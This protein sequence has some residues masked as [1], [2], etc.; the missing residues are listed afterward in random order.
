LPPES[1]QT[2]HDK[3]YLKPM[4]QAWTKSMGSLGIW[5]DG[6][7]VDLAAAPEVMTGP[8]FT[9]TRLKFI[10]EEVNATAIS[11]LSGAVTHQQVP[12][13]FLYMKAL[14]MWTIALDARQALELAVQTSSLLGQSAETT[15]GLEALLLLAQNVASEM[16]RGTSQASVIQAID[17][18]RP[19]MMHR[20][21]TLDTA[22]LQYA[23]TGSHENLRALLHLASA[24]I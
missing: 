12:T 13:M 14:F 3:P 16:I 8:E 23:I 20:G 2:L 7:P 18:Q 9:T 5:P 24:P 15:E 4:M 11:V 19:T 1:I 6:S 22:I 21:S 10:S 17:D